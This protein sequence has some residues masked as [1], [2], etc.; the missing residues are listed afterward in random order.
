MQPFSF[1]GAELAVDLR[2]DPR[3]EGVGLRNI[4]G[5]RGGRSAL[6]CVKGRAHAILSVKLR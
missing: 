6:N 3:P 1:C 4:S 2:L 5:L